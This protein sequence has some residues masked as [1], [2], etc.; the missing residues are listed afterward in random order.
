MMGGCGKE[1]GFAGKERM[2]LVSG[3]G[4]FFGVEAGG[5]LSGGRLDGMGYFV[6]LAVLVKQMAQ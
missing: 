3:C 2:V 4:V 5:W 6:D 1:S